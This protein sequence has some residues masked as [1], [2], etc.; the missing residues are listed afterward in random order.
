ML[1]RAMELDPGR[2]YKDANEFREALRRVG[3]SETRAVSDWRDRGLSDSTGP[4]NVNV[5]VVNKPAAIDPFDSYSILKPAEIDWLLPKPSRRPFVVVGLIGML[6]VG[7]VLAFSNTDGWTNLS[8][9]AVDYI[10]PS[11]DLTN[12]NS[13]AQEKSGRAQTSNQLNTA[14][15]A[16]AGKPIPRE[17]RV[18]KSQVEAGTKQNRKSHAR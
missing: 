15:S 7:A 14:R 8:K 9:A 18:R 4:P 2:R 10:Q 3:R 12:A 17:Q 11:R 16:G 1:L 13:T 5:T 6:L